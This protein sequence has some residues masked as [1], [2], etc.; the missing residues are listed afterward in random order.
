M[1]KNFV[2]NGTLD[3]GTVCQVEEHSLPQGVVNVTACHPVAPGFISNPH[4][5]HTVPYYVS[6]VAGLKPEANISST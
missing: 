3:S 6:Q 4:F 2:D 5:F 1:N